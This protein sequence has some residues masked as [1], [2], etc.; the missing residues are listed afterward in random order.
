MIEN[1]LLVSSAPLKSY[2]QQD[3][4]VTKFVDTVETISPIV[5]RCFYVMMAALLEIDQSESS[6]KRTRR[7]YMEG[8][9]HGF[10]GAIH[11][12]FERIGI[13]IDRL[14]TFSIAHEQK[15]LSK[16]LQE[17]KMLS[18]EDTTLAEKIC[19]MIEKMC[20]PFTVYNQVNTMND[21]HF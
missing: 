6:E 4:A 5:D 21:Q 20:F 16:R 15:L 18:D 7:Y 2:S 13:S 10:I 14:L 19:S 11:L 9:L 12:L 3:A 8:E 1:I 17:R